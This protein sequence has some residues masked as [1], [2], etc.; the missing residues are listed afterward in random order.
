MSGPALHRFE[1]DG[2]FYALDP[3]SCF[4]FECDAISWDVLE[5]YPHTPVNRILALLEDKHPRVELEEV[6]G[7]LEWLR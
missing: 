6:V 1:V 5:H 7:E 4:C 2:H 3:E